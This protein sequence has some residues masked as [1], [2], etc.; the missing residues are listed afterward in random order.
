M[1]NSSI[2]SALRSLSSANSVS[3]SSKS[4]KNCLVAV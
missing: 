2:F 4:F 3:M 1:R